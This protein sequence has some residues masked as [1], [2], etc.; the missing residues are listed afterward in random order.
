MM[1]RM[2]KPGISAEK[3]RETEAGTLS[4]RV[5]TQLRRTIKANISATAIPISMPE[6]ML[7]PPSQLAPIA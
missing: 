1:E 7:A 2:I 4:G 3:E 5:M 6:M